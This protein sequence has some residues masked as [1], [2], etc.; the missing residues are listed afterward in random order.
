MAAN[1][2]TSLK[3]IRI[4][5]IDQPTYSEVRTSFFARYSIYKGALKNGKT[6]QNEEYSE[7]LSDH[8]MGLSSDIKECRE[9]GKEE[10]MMLDLIKNEDAKMEESKGGVDGNTVECQYC[11]QQIIIEFLMQ[12]EDS[13]CLAKLFTCRVCKDQFPE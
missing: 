2:D 13:E 5:I 9:K 4:V 6:A 10:Q 1:H 3:D 12:H 11:K 8:M 7:M